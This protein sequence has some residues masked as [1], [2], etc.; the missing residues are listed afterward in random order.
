MLKS[1]RRGQTPIDMRLDL[2]GET[3]A[4]AQRLIERVLAAGRARGARVV[5]IVT[6]TGSRRRLDLDRPVPPEEQA[7]GVLRRM[8]PHWLALP[9]LSD[10]VLGLSP[11]AP[12]HGG[13]GAFY[14]LL[15]RERTV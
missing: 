2:H 1:I 10:W 9:P 13:A 12:H 4:R 15:R 3:Q 5:L 6:G 7:P 8:L 14:V 11:A